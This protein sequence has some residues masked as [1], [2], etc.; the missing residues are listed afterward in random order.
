MTKKLYWFWICYCFI[1]KVT[2]VI[3]DM[4]K[5]G[6]SSLV[7]GEKIP[8]VILPCLHLCHSTGK[9]IGEFCQNCLYYL[10]QQTGLLG[11]EVGIS[12][13]CLLTLFINC[14]LAEFL[15]SLHCWEFIILALRT[16]ATSRPTTHLFNRFHYTLGFE[17]LGR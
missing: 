13:Q 4:V 10:K 17:E 15:Q 9:G 1:F 7:F 6:K 2:F 12:S 16:L 11:R 8:K 5:R 14:V 3:L